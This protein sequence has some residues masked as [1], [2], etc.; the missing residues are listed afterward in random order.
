MATAPGPLTVLDVYVRPDVRPLADDACLPSVHE[1]PREPGDLHHVP[2]REARVEYRAR[3]AAPHHAWEDEV[4][5]R[6]PA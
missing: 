4:R 3:A 5:P 2:T 6:Y 1:R